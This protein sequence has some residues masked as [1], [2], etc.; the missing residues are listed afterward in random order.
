[1]LAALGC[2]DIDELFRCVPQAVRLPRALNLPGPLAELEVRER[3]REL[4]EANA[5]AR[6]TCLLG[7]GVYDHYVPAAVE[8]I[9]G[10]AEF[11]TAY[12]PYQPELSQGMLAAMYEFQSMVCELTA[13]DVANA[14]LY[15]GATALAEA[16]FVAAGATGRTEIVLPQAV[17]PRYRDVLATQVAASGLR[18]ISVP[19]EGGR[20]APDA[21]ARAVSERC[22]AV[23]VQQPNYFGCIEETREI[24]EA[25]HRAG[26]LLIA[27]VDP[28]SLALLEP[29]GEYGADIAVGEGQPLG[30]PLSYGGPLLG[31]F[32]CTRRLVRR[33]PGRVVGRTVDAAGRVAYTLTLQTREQHI[34]RERAT[35]NICTNQGLCALAATV[36]L[37]ALGKHGLRQVAELCLQRTHYFYDKLCALKR[38]EPVFFAPFFR[39]FVVR[40]AGERAELAR[41]LERADAAIG[42]EVSREAG[43]EGAYLVAV[44]EK[45]SRARLDEILASLAESEQGKQ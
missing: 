13:L 17:N 31:L 12:T 27:C 41:A 15:D 8:H 9:V 14:S 28:I 40:Y 45:V 20:T 22:A 29:P 11:F 3:V 33:M 5:G 16:A 21:V 7:G 36:Y 4:A 32:A 23:V 39:E 19:H 1:M 42:P 30:L 2:A 6:R 24:S 26:A 34:R 37:A 35:S 25:A 44:T 18:I 38:W 43:V 10:R